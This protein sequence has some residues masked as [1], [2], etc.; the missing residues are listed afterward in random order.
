MLITAALATLVSASGADATVQGPSYQLL[1][2]GTLGG[3]SSYASAI[4]DRGHVVGSSQ[5]G[6]GTWHGFLWRSGTMTDLGL[7]RPNGINNQD[8][9]IGTTEADTSA[10]LWRDGTITRLG[11][12]GG[13]W[14]YPVAIN[15]RGQVVGTSSTADAVDAVFLWSCGLMRP[16]PLH[17]VSDINIRGQVAGGRRHEPG[18]HHAAVWWRGKVTDLGAGPFDRS[19]TSGIDVRGWA[20]GWQFSAAQ[21]ERGVLW[22]RGKAV[23]LGTLGGAATHVIAINDRGQILGTSETAGGDVH[24]FLW[25][26]GIMT[27]LTGSGVDPDHDFVGLNDRGE[28][29]TSFRPEWGTSHAAI[30]RPV[31][32]GQQIPGS[33]ESA[34]GARPATPRCGDR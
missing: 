32:M 5:V 33:A 21:D 15:D 11:S 17:S 12:L 7:F 10:Y 25:Q 34:A 19:N 31:R 22:R 3:Q 8:E 4:N 28:I 6:D 2:L 23:D 20:V 29:A 26:R 24:P 1:D 30:Y 9:L 27:D 14:T 13:P 16:L 18:G